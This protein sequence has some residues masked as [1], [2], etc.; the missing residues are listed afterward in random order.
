MKLTATA[1][2][3]AVA[4]AVLARLV[5]GPGVLGYDAVWALR[6]GGEIIHGTAPAFEADFAPTPH[7][8]ANLVSAVVSLLGPDGAT[9]V[10]LGLSWLA[11]GALAVALAWLGA[12][13]LSWPVGVLAAAIV[14]TRVQFTVETA[15]A[16]VDLPFL[17]LAI[18]AA[19]IEVRRPRLGLAVPIL[20]V[21]AGLL[22]PE[23]WALEAA[24]LAYRWSDLDGAGRARLAGLLAIAPALWAGMDLWATGDLLHSLH[25]TQE[26]GEALGRPTGSRTALSVAPAALRDIVQ[27]PMLWVALAGAAAGLLYRE[28]ASALPG[29][30]VGV[31]LLG[32]MVLGVA[33]LPVLGRY[34]LLPAVM[35]TLFA[36]LAVFGWTTAGPGR[37]R[38]W[39]L[40]GAVAAAVILA[41]VP[42]DF[43]DLEHINDFTS[44]R[45][46]IQD[47]LR[48]AVRATDDVACERIIAP[49]SRSLAVIRMQRET[50]RGTSGRLFFT[51]TDPAV[52]EEYGLGRTGPARPR[53]GARELHV[54]RYYRVSALG[55]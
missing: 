10:L 53:A 11:L 1:G 51:S 49:D 19:A 13:L 7:P 28:R 32:F 17:A 48:A 18:S 55:C 35:L 25:G 29:A 31:G 34:L 14:V 5:Y 30:V 27:T 46:E 6:W 38:V 24:Y 40:G 9:T 21:L 54:G 41:G 44:L 22:R 26:L 52:L 36:G 15:Q 16:I 23:G 33:G 45:H 20:L 42:Q 50:D 3:S 2:L 12:A 8:L 4:V 39:M 37:R 47:D 43:D